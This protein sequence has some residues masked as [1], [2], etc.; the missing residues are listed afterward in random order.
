MAFNDAVAGLKQMSQTTARR[1]AGDRTARAIL[2]IAGLALVS[3]AAFFFSIMTGA[4]N[5]SV[6]DVMTGML[7]G[8]V[9]SALS[10]RDR[11][12]IFDIRLPRAMLGFLIGGG[13][14]VSG[15]VMQGLFRN[16]L[17][18]PGLIGVSAGSSLGAVSMIVLGGGVLAPVAHL[19]G[20]FAL[21]LAA[22]IGGLVTTILLYRIATRQGQTSIATM[23][24]AGIALGSLALAATGILIYMADDR[25][26]RD[27]TF[28]SMGSLA[29]STWSKVSGAGPIIVLSLLPLPFMARGLNALTLGEAA[30]FHMG[31]SVQRLKNIAVVSVAAAVGA[32]VAVSGGIGFVGIVVP[33]ILRMVIGP[34]HRFLLPASA[35]LGGSLLIVA[36][37]VAR[38]I[39]SPA[40]LP[41]GIL[42][43]GVGGPF[44]LWMLLRQR[45][46]L[47]L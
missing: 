33:H 40:E 5:A 1:R 23:L 7:G 28:W 25:Q 16:P 24:L 42:T 32:S 45:S 14:A 10:N 19:F 39:V 47:S 22:F 27:L 43:A 12:V 44:F 9:E 31:I 13:L 20:I 11:I 15:A 36:D 17:A 34:D 30:A 38:T 35:L 8:S 3:A 4:S 6:F 18:D 41:I 46:R 29:G 26:L 2:V 37:V 21:P